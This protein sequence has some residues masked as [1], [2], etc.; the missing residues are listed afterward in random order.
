MKRQIR[1]NVFETNSSSSHSIVITKK[2]EYY[3]PE[4][5]ALEDWCKGRKRFWADSLYFGRSPFQCLHTFWQKVAYAIANHSSLPVEEHINQIEEICR[6]HSHNFVCFE[7]EKTVPFCGR[8]ENGTAIWGEEELE[9]GGTDDDILYPWL[10]KNNVS[11][12]EFLTNKKYIVICDGDEYCI[13]QDLKKS[14]LINE[15]LKNYGI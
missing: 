14:G 7:F 1:K 10:K 8:D 12:E 3:T 9:L 5:M 2:D 6:K 11:L 15:D 13:W 4:E